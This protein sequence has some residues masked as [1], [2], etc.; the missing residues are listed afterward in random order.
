MVRVE[1][2]LLLPFLTHT[3]YAGLRGLQVG[4]IQI[5]VA[6]YVQDTCVVELASGMNK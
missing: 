3:I 4:L 2:F 1:Y 5:F 6:L